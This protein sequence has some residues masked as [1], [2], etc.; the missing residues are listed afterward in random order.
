MVATL[1]AIFGLT[2]LVFSA[3]LLYVGYFSIVTVGVLVV[4]LKRCT[5]A[6]FT[7]LVGA[8]YKVKALKAATTPNSS[9][10]S[11]I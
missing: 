6:T 1:A 3:V 11:L 4:C 7:I 2:T 5:V 10:W 9:K 8:I